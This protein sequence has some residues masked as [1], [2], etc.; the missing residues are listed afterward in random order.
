MDAKLEKTLLSRPPQKGSFRTALLGLSLLMLVFVLDQQSRLGLPESISATRQQVFGQQ[1]YWRA[2]TTALLHADLGHLAANSLFFT[3]LAYLLN[4]YFGAWAFP[5]L[6]LVA[7]GLINLIVLSIY[8]EGVTLVGISGVVY[9]MASF[10]LTLYC[11][12]QRGVSPG[13]R[14]VN[15]VAL[16][17]MLLFPALFEPRVSYLSHAVGFALGIPFGALF[18]G[19]RKRGIR[20]QETWTEPQNDEPSENSVFA[21]NF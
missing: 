15:A 11:F 8:P 21:L 4:G 1:Q 14:L 20:A 18:F 10:W 3:G 5:V 16:S 12:I 19:L 9:F 17:L 6:S 2:F 7:G 13:R